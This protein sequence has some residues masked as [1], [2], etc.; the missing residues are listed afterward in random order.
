MTSRQIKLQQYADAYKALT[1]L[2]QQI[3][4]TAWQ[5]RPAENAWTIHE[6]IIHLAD[7]EA[8]GYIRC[9]KAIAEPGGI[10][11]PIDQDRWTSGLHYHQQSTDTALELFRVLRD[12][13]TA[14]LSMLSDEQWEASYFNHP[15][16]GSVPLQA[17][18]QTYTQHAV[19]HMAQI[20]RNYQ[21]WKA[22]RKNT[23][24]S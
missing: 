14:L 21:A 10:I 15:E 1:T 5:Y 9:L 3:P 19:T 13:T 8:N 20:E 12:K 23:V 4:N 18:L 6:I 24:N 7:A 22:F 16:S 11:M 2:L 17:W